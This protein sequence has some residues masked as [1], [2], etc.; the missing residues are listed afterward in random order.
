MSLRNICLN[1]PDRN[2]ALLNH[3]VVLA[4]FYI[5]RCFVQGNRPEYHTFIIFVN[6]VKRIEKY[7]GV[8]TETVDNFNRK[9]NVNND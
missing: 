2:A 6:S 8:T 3:I 4:K 5:F 9:W 7:I 1:T